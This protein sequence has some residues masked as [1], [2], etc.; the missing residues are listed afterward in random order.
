MLDALGDQSVQSLERRSHKLV[1]AC[2]AGRA[3]CRK[4]S[5]AFAGDL[6]IGGARE[7]QLEFV[8]P[9]APVDEVGVAID[10]GGRDPAAFAIDDPRRGARGGRKLILRANEDDSSVARGDRAGFDDP[11]PRAPFD[12]GRKTG[13]EPNRI[14]DG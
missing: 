9:I 2:G 1:F 6:L 12:Q 8:R 7:S 14:R 13:V 5:A 10:E 4:N 3:D 11:Q